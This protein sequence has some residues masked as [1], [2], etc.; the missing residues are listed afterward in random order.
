MSPAI[1]LTGKSRDAS[2]GYQ[3]ICCALR[4]RRRP[5]NDD[6]FVISVTEL[7]QPPR[8]RALAWLNRHVL[9]NRP[10][11]P[12]REMWA[13]LGAGTHLALDDGSEGNEL[14]MQQRVDA[15]T[16][17][18][19]SDSIEERLLNFSVRDYKTASAASA[20]YG[21]KDE[22]IA[23]ANLYAHLFR[24]FSWQGKPSAFDCSDIEVVVIYKDWKVRD[25][26]K[27]ILQ[28]TVYRCPVWSHEECSD[29]LRGR[30]YLHH[31]ALD[32]LGLLP[33]RDLGPDPL[34]LQRC[35]KAEVWG[36]QRCQHYCPVSDFCPKEERP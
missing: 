10:A 23:Q 15:W 8:I 4:A 26:E 29:F 12:E 35:T 5:P 2:R 21:C 33:P 27:G 6:P 22:W 30:L 3:A 1:T 28:P 24:L 13:L 17:C 14:Q 7:L 16:V 34:P 25:G 18:G 32:S 20:P 19:R 9:Y 36:G 31:L 11:Q